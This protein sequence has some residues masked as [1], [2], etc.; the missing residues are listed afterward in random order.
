MFGPQEGGRSDTRVVPKVLH[1]TDQASY[2]RAVPLKPR[3]NCMAASSASL[4][5]Y[6]EFIVNGLD[7]VSFALVTPELLRKIR[8][9]LGN[10]IIITLYVLW[11]AVAVYI[12][13]N[14]YGFLSPP[15]DYIWRMPFNE[16]ISRLIVF[17]TAVGL[18][19]S[20]AVGF[21]TSL[22]VMDRLTPWITANAFSVG[23]IVFIISRITAL[24]I[25]THQVFNGH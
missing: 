20:W 11:G 2:R 23:V 7:L 6:K 21:F 9:S 18:L 1:G 13:W 8:P 24:L 12:F 10:T 3:E 17:C 4:E 15:T 5:H 19:V 14:F 25:A 16:I 22:F